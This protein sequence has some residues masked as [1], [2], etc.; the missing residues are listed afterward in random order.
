MRTESR[1]D[2][3]QTNARVSANIAN[4]FRATLRVKYSDTAYAKASERKQLERLVARADKDFRRFFDF[5]AS[6]AGRDFSHT[7]PCTYLIERLTYADAIT[8][9]QMAD[10][11]MPS[12]GRTEQDMRVFASAQ[13]AI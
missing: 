10:V 2:E 3:L 7:V 1:Y 4:A 6:I 5:L 13:G 9:G 11:P 8:T 12:W